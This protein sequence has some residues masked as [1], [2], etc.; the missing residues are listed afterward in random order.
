MGESVAEAGADNWR[1]LAEKLE[2]LNLQ[3]ARRREARRNVLHGTCVALCAGILNLGAFLLTWG[4]PYLSWDYA[5]PETAV[6]GVAVHA[7]EWLFVR[8]APVALAGAVV[9]AVLTRRRG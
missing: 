7:L 3:L 2:I 6:L 8:L 5:D 1:V 9:G 4:S